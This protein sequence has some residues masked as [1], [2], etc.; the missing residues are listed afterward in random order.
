MCKGIGGLPTTI[1][2]ID[3][4]G[5]P[6]ANFCISPHMDVNNMNACADRLHVAMQ[7]FLH[8]SLFVC[9]N[10]PILAVHEAHVR[11]LLGIV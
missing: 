1:E 8:R 3:R 5:L 9:T 11:E 6:L 7:Q 2:Y 4:G 10:M